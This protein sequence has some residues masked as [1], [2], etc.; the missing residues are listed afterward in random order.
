MA[1]LPVIHTSRSNP[2]IKAK[3][4]YSRY[5]LGLTSGFLDGDFQCIHCSRPVVFNPVQ[6]GVQNRNHCPY[7]LWSKH[8][9]LER[10]GDRLAACKAPMKPVGLSLKQPHKRYPVC[11]GGELMVI[12][13]CVECGKTSVNRVAADDLADSLWSTFESSLEMSSR[14]RDRL[15]DSEI[16]HLG[17]A[18]AQDMRVRLF[19]SEGFRPRE[20][21][22]HSSL[23]L[24]WRYLG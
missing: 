7:C 4:K 2:R 5:R 18:S 16:A 20:A 19:G 6:S 21:L 22:I 9:D 17:S 12:H 11:R 10:A 15:A 23:V 1:K 14:L 24:D 3:L 8:L 13:L